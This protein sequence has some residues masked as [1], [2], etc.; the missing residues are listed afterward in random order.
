MI[1]RTMKTGISEE[2]GNRRF[3]GYKGEHNATEL[4][5]VPPSNMKNNKEITN[6]CV[7]FLNENDELF[8][9]KVYDFTQEIKVRLWSQLTQ[10]SILDVY[11]EGYDK[12]NNLVVKSSVIANLYFLEASG[13]ND[14]PSEVDSDS[15][16][17]QVSQIIEK[18]GNIGETGGLDLSEYLKADKAEDTFVKKEN[19]K[20]LSSN[21]Y[22]N[23]EKEKL[24]GIEIG[25]QKNHTKLSELEND[26]KFLTESEIKELIG[27]PVK[28]INNLKPDNSGNVTLEV[29]SGNDGKSAYEIA[30]EC[31]YEGSKENWVSSLKG[32]DG[33]T[34]TP[35]IS[36]SG[37]LSWS[38]DDGKP[39]PPSVNI[40][41]TDGKDGK[42]GKD[43]VVNNE[44]IV[45]AVE[46]YLNEHYEP[47][48]TVIKTWTKNDI[49]P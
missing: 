18:I 31:G 21:D 22:S 13:G 15:I 30:V 16:G 24:S 44:E 41:G 11:L 37:V 1:L 34:Y 23:E 27:N 43:G 45:S 7:I 10:N 40:K 19:G 5:I 28:S 6:C 32:E 49:N 3:A 25:A 2:I 12:N 47:T 14:T 29:I 39:N 20:M 35:S 38:N 46:S 48:T 42:D 36:E 33:T 9:S 17:A 8:R 26:S 4:I